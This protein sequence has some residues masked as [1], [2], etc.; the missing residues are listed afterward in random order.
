MEHI[1]KS[2]EE[3]KEFGRTISASLKGGEVLALTGDLGSG[4][5]T[6]VQGL[7]EGLAI[8]VRV[9]S[10]TFIIIRKYKIPL[11]TKL[12]GIKNFYHID[13]YRLEGV[14]ESELVNLGI[15]DILGKKENVTA[16]EWAEKATGLYPDDIAWLSFSD[17]GGNKR[18]IIVGK[19]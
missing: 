7:A 9:I 4:K 17:M 18:K 11:A 6:F 13:L 14:V 8:D 3:T 15:K 16:I 10:P 12:K 2:A 1:T 5:T 19:P